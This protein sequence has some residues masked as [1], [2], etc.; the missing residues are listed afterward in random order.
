M[1]WAG[2]VAL[3]LAF[4]AGLA[5]GLLLGM[6]LAAMGQQA[7][8][9][10]AARERMNLGAVMHERKEAQRVGLSSTWNPGASTH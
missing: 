4:V 3:L 7:A 9:A 6:V 5:L 10:R 2:I 1:T 8:T